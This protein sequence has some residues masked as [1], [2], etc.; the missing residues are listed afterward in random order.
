MD[1]ILIAIE[2]DLAGHRQIVQEVLEVL[3]KELLFLIAIFK[4]VDYCGNS[5]KNVHQ[6]DLIYLS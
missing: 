6:N 5:Q 4:R 2:D 1:N 3:R